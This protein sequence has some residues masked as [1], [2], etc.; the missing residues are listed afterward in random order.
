[1]KKSDHRKALLGYAVVLGGEEG[2]ATLADAAPKVTAD[3]SPARRGALWM[4][5]K[6]LDVL[7]EALGGAWS[8][9]KDELSTWLDSLRGPVRTHPI[10][11]RVRLGYHS[12]FDTGVDVSDDAWSVV[13]GDLAFDRS[14]SGLV[15]GTVP[16]STRFNALAYAVTYLRKGPRSDRRFRSP[17]WAAS[18]QAMDEP[19]YD[20]AAHLE[21]AMRLVSREPQSAYVQMANAAS[22]A[23]GRRSAVAGNAHEAALSLSQRKRWSALTAV[24][25]LQT[26]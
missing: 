19:S 23:A 10:V 26:A 1:M 4:A 6:R 11:R 14:Y 22:F 18:E 8:F 7:F 13:T 12:R 24:L 15:R 9:E 17:L 3:A 20:G 16:G 2:V 25:S 21:A 5:L